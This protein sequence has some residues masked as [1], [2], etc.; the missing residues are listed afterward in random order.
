MKQLGT[1]LLLG[2]AAGATSL[3]CGTQYAEPVTRGTEVDPCRAWTSEAECEADQT[4][5]CTVQPN[6]VG[7][8]TTDPNC[9]KFTCQGGV[10]F[11]T[12]SGQVLLLHDQPFR[13]VGVNSWAIAWDPNGCRLFEYD[14]QEDALA[15]MFDDMVTL[16]ATV[17]RIWAFQTYAG[18]SGTDYSRLDNVVRYARRANVRL[19]FVLENGRA[20]N[21]S[22]GGDRDD[23]WYATNYLAPYD[24]NALSYPDYVRGLVRHFATEPTILAWELVHEAQTSSFDALNGFVRDMSRHIRDN[25][26]NHLISAGVDCGGAEATDRT[27]GPPSSYYKLNEHD[28]VHL[29]DVHEFVSPTVPLTADQSACKAIAESLNK[30]MFFGAIGISV[31][32]SASQLATR[33]N[34][35][36]SKVD[37]AFARGFVGSLI[38]EYYPDWPVPSAGTT[39]FDCRAEDPLGRPNG[40]AAA[41]A[42]RYTSP[43]VHE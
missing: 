39:R 30:P 36:K 18:A 42:A 41:L 34:Q 40:I 11:V 29:L 31:D 5:G 14:N 22:R 10:P 24:T 26:G 7:C 28:T 38:Y 16:G 23:S 17:A 33:A 19:I 12:R 43:V 2:C 37:A 35:M 27:D 13:F 3:G 4:H 25:D 32:G 6:P 8:R 15:R 1:I 20:D 9:P 21:C